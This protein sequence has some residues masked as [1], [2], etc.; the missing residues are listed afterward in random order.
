MAVKEH[1]C[2]FAALKHAPSRMLQQQA[3]QFPR[4]DENILYSLLC[5]ATMASA[6]IYILD[7]SKIDREGTKNELGSSA[8]GMLYAARYAGE[9]VAIRVLDMAYVEEEDMWREV[10]L[11]YRLRHR[12]VVA[13]KGACVQRFEDGSEGFIVLERTALSLSAA[14]FGEAAVVPPPSLAV[15]LHWVLQVLSAL[16]FMHAH[17]IIHG[18]LTSDSVFLDAIPTATSGAVAKVTDFGLARVRQAAAAT[19]EPLW[20]SR[21]PPRWMDP[22]LLD[23]SGSLTAGSDLYAWAMLAWEALALVHPFAE[24]FLGIPEELHL[25]VLRRH[26]CVGG[27]RPSLTRLLELGLPVALTDLLA[28]CWSGTV[29]ARPSA[30]MAER[31]L[32]SVLAGMIKEA[33]ADACAPLGPAGVCASAPRYHMQ[34]AASVMALSVPEYDGAPVR[35]VTRWLR[36]YQPSTHIKLHTACE[37]SDLSLL[38]GS[39]TSLDMSVE[40]D[41]FRPTSSL[42]TDAGLSRMVNLTALN[43]EGCGSITDVGLAP[44]VRHLT[45]LNIYRCGG[46]TD[47]SL[48]QA[49]NLTT[50]NMGVCEGITD[51]GLSPLVKLTTLDM[52]VC[53]GIT[54]VGLSQLA[55]LHTL[56]MTWCKRIGNAGL[57]GLVNLT[58][59]NMDWCSEITDAAL[60]G[61]ANLTSLSMRG[62]S[63]I[64]DAGLSQLVKLTH[65]NMSRC[66]WITNAGLSPLVN[67]VNLNMTKCDGI[68]DAGL[69]H[70]DKL[71]NLDVSWCE[72]ISG[73]GLSRLV[74]LTS[75]DVS[76]T[77][78]TDAGL[79]GLVNLKTLDMSGCS[80]ITD[81]GLSCLVNL[82][83][84]EMSDCESITDAGLTCLAH[85]AS[86]N[87][88]ECEAITDAGLSRL[89]TLTALDASLCRGITDASL[90]RLVGL[91][92]LNISGCEAITD[93]GLTCL[94]RLATLNMSGC[95][96]ITDAGLSRMV[97]LSTL[98]VS[99]CRAITD[100]GLVRLVNLT[101]LDTSGCDG[102]TFAGLSR[103]VNPDAGREWM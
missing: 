6:P 42:M 73:A 40:H 57:A 83:K 87:M 12:N 95:D 38:P 23:G 21:A 33:T 72:G 66:I 22:A 68:T 99:L 32:Q 79:A 90:S 18:G 11:H 27:G 86:L 59:L 93:A 7:P 13:V 84:L 81:A 35:Q 58:T 10:D 5:L 48:S 74:Q 45:S 39:L 85:L 70:L 34:D 54:E 47:A 20:A 103:M 94:V 78:I 52:G 15:R 92:T 55:N 1:L 77:G 80:K 91:T 101:A 60:H 28:A 49:V 41:S 8:F 44:L 102:I 14:L 51:A 75:L 46:I 64:T 69:A 100:A 65:L 67:L 82:T 89:P 17:G 16:R 9:P 53:G 4:L 88:S 19:T 56:N 2:R 62:C 96:G 76:N 71:T 50:L 98:D 37:D 3:H 25:A 30:A 43:M 97:T 29:T 63:G 36:V 61:L 26:V 31:A 24:L